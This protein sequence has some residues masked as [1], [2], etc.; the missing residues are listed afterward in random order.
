M[1]DLSYRELCRSIVDETVESLT[2]KPIK[3]TTV[4]RLKLLCEADA[5]YAELPQPIRYG[6]AIG[7][8]LGGC[9]LPIKENDLILGRIYE[10][11][12][13]AEEE[14]LLTRLTKAGNC[15]RPLWIRDSGHRSFAWEEL[16]DLGLTGLRARAARELEK[17]RADGVT[18]PPRLELLE[19]MILVYDAIINYLN[20]YADAAEAA[21]LTEAAEVCRA[22]TMREPRSFREALQLLWTVQ[23]V[24]CAYIAV[25]PSLSVG[26][27]DLFLERIYESDRASGRLTADDAR[28]LILDFYR[29]H[30]LILGR[31]EHQMSV[32]NENGFTGWARN[33]CYDSPQYV[34]LGGRRRDGSYLDG[35]LTHLFVEMIEPRFKNPVAVI[36][37]APEMQKI[38][39]AL[40]RKIADKARA[41]ASLMIYNEADVIGG[42]VRSGVLP[43]EAAEFEHYGCNHPTLPGIEAFTRYDGFLP[44]TLFMEILN[45]WAD[46][47]HEPQS[48]E[49]LY[50]AIRKEVVSRS[51]GIIDRLAATYA[52]R[53]ARPV[54]DLELT[55]CFYRYTA[56][57]AA[58][59][60]CY[61]SK[62]IFANLHICSYASFVD[63]IV[64][65]DEL[66]IKRKKLTLAR[67]ME[68]T[69]ANFEGYPTELALCRKV[70]KRGSDDPTVNAHAERLMTAFT[71]DIF[72]LAEEKLKITA[73][74]SAY[75]DIAEMPRPLIRIS[76]ESDNGHLD[77]CK[78]GATPDG[79]RAGVP[80][81]QNTGPSLG[82]SV[83]G[84]TA[85]LCSLS[86]IPFDRIVAGAQ[87]LSIQPKYFVGDEGLDRLAGVMGG[88]FDMGGLQLQVT[89]T[90]PSILREAQKDP[91]SHRDL[92]VRITGYS[93]VFVDMEKAAQDDIIRR[94]AME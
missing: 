26:R 15:A 41:S 92:M 38:C 33:G 87:N 86:S 31:G 80:L 59:F 20:R 3:S 44:L 14:E 74:S 65:V 4:E 57:R 8:L 71:D 2:K 54:A 79:R 84:L 22:L 43:S 73:K 19:G 75:A 69:R 16:I 7:H 36:R 55:D 85:R 63:V 9:S 91:D 83:S 94:E 24:Y 49:E 64:A 13:D 61:G 51:A 28:V 18:E 68:A 50:S 58:S 70:P 27:T 47:G 81:S 12:L 42:F 25:N 6:R 72:A 89:A 37:Y 29:K 62:Y 53:M 46:E 5:T 93:A 1:T 78:M 35:E 40:W 17:R 76:M 21:G 11:E 52:E 34:I 88:Y 30:N 60:K 67:L 23:L 39:P 56:T 82:A 90:D 48:T 66:V 32:T 10:R 77:G 45:R